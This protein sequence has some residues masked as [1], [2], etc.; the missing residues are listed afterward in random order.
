MSPTTDEVR[1]LETTF[2]RDLRR[3]VDG[4]RNDIGGVKV[5]MQNMV[6][7]R[8]CE[9]THQ[10]EAVTARRLEEKI[11]STK[12]EIL[13]AVREIKSEVGEMVNGK[14]QTSIHDTVTEVT[15]RHELAAL[16]RKR[17]TTGVFSKLGRN[18]Q[19]LSAIIALIVTLGGACV[20]G[21]YWVVGAMNVLKKAAAEAQMTA[22]R[23]GRL[24][25]RQSKLLEEQRETDAA[26]LAATVWG[27]DDA[28]S[29]DSSSK[30]KPT[31]PT[32]KSAAK[33]AAKR[34]E[35]PQ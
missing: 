23:Q 35:A 20:G 19:M 14:L 29:E 13:S 26:T 3:A 6:T 33:K 10:A 27:N 1:R 2:E 22:E 30:K 34:E 25:E 24:I 9:A 5:T 31:K 17:P 32:K 4:L 15:E 12:S 16:R 11:E 8:E 28:A 18:A 7:A 21:S